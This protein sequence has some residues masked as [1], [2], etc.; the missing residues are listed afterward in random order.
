V[1]GEVVTKTAVRIENPKP[2]VYKAVV[3]SYNVLPTD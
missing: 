2:T 3:E 1:T